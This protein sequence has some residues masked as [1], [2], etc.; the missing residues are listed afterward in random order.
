MK[1]KTILHFIKAESG[2][3][4]LIEPPD[5]KCILIDSGYKST[6][7]Y[8]L[9][10]L[11]LELSS[12]GCRISLFVIT[13]I[14]EDHIGGA[15]S[16][17]SENGDCN[18]PQ[19]IPIDNIWFNGI[20]SIFLNSSQLYNHLFEHLSNEDNK[21]IKEITLQLSKLIRVGEGP[22]SANLSEAFEIICKK[23][24]YNLNFGKG[25]CI[26]TDD[27][28]NIGSCFVKVLSPSNKYIQKFEKWIDK[29]CIDCLNKNYKLDKN[30]SADFLEKLIMVTGKEDNG[31]NGSSEIASKIPDI[32]EWFGTSTK[33]PMNDVNRASIVIEIDCLGKK[34]LFMG[35]SESEDWISKAQKYYDYVKISHHGT[36]K[37]NKVLLDS[38]SI[39]SAI[40]STNGKR[41]HPEDELLAKIIKSGVKN[42]Y[43][44]YDIRRKDNIIALQEKFCFKSYFGIKRILF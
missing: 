5:K 15:I 43:F 10:P 34:L 3:C 22:I 18:N 44:N 1:Q 13:H 37:A 38:I 31:T 6:Y 26:L 29:N 32:E 25:N 2:D 33:S 14:D 27:S 11:L 28:M 39:D 8:E 41:N 20:L 4:F 35:D 42:I 24:H 23:N 7:F 30:K 40:I 16:L 36:Y 17:L 19:I 12:K 9:K 21:K